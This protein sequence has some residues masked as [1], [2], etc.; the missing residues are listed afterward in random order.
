VRRVSRICHFGSL[1]RS[2]KCCDNGHQHMVSHTLSLTQSV[3]FTRSPMKQ[4]TLLPLPHL[5]LS[6]L[7]THTHTHRLRA[8][9]KCI[10]RTRGVRLKRVGRVSRVSRVSRV[11]RVSRVSRVSW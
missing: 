10:I 8:D 2:I 7:R 9:E 5:Y 11:G 4:Q 3:A 1:Q 6:A